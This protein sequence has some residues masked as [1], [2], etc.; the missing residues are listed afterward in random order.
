LA[1]MEGVLTGIEQA[2]DCSSVGFVI[3]ELQIHGC[4]HT[5]YFVPFLRSG[6]DFVSFNLSGS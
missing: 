2:V 3:G 5:L 1:V 4:D 6:S